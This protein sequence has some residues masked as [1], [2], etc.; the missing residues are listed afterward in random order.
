MNTEEQSGTGVVKKDRHRVLTFLFFLI[1]SALLWFIIK[2]TD[3][4]STQTEFLVRYTEI[5]AN[6]WMSSPEQR[7]KLSFVGDGFATLHHH[8]VRPQK[9]V[10]E[11]PLSEVNY[12]LE[13][14]NT[15]SY[16]GQYVAERVARWLDVPI[17]SVTMSDDKQYF[18]MEDLQSKE[19]PVR[20]RLDLQTQRQ[21]RLYDVPLADPSS[22]TVYGPRNV[23]DTLDEVYTSVLKAYNVNSDLEREVDVDLYD[24]VIRSD[25]KRVRAI[26]DVEQYTE[27]DVEVPVTVDDTLV[28]RFFPETMKVKC[29]VAIKDFATINGKAF[30]VLADTAQLH[31]RQPLLDIRLARVPE[32]VVVMKTEPDQVEYLIVN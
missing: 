5:P 30:L 25:T 15:Y 8:L 21:Y 26:I 17:S 7:V 11:I 28:V 32:H 20:V 16:S 31:C 10:V 29:M 12:R 22:I 23:L 6:K 27:T 3:D 1:I 18:N 24:G 19:L 9:R 14:G 4:Y 13:G 2:L